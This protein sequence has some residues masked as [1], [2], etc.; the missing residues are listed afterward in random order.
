MNTRILGLCVAMSFLSSALIYVYFKNKVTKVDEKLDVLYQL[1]QSHASET[2]MYRNQQQDIQ[3]YPKQEVSNLITV[4]DG[5]ASDSGSDSDDSDSD[6]SDTESNELVIGD[7]ISNETQIKKISL[8]LEENN[9]ELN[10]SEIIDN[11]V[12]NKVKDLD[13]NFDNLRNEDVTNFE[14]ADG[15]INADDEKEDD[16]ENVGDDSIEA[17]QHTTTSES[18]NDEKV[19][20]DVS[21]LNEISE[22]TLNKDTSENVDVNSEHSDLEKELTVEHNS[23]ELLLNENL[24]NLNVT[25]EASDAS[26]ASESSEEE[27]DYSR[28]RVVDLKKIC[29]DKELTNYNSLKK[30][31]LVELLMNHS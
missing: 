13:I 2:E 25:T 24:E 7:S 14:L 18:S 5:E 27:I 23:E 1:I 17:N 22:F 30:S 16:E 12:L 11:I 4:S 28:L 31:E 10:Q 20:L 9:D 3:F 6:D 15:E 8:D 19:S 26:D 29:R 21:D